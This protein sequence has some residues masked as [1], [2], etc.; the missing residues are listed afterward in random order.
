MLQCGTD[1]D[2]RRRRHGETLSQ[3]GAQKLPC[4]LSEAADADLQRILTGSITHWGL[5]A[6]NVTSLSFTRRSRTWRRFRTWGGMR[7]TYAR[8]IYVPAR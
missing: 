8:D 7:G 3:T 2:L 6:R 5:P 4:R 1:K